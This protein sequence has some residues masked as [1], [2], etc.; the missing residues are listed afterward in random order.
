MVSLQHVEWAGCKKKVEG[1]QEHGS[2]VRELGVR[3]TEQQFPMMRCSTKIQYIR[4][5]V[6]AE[7][8]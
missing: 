6:I 8:R 2:G 3:S 5:V 4:E 1:A 7:A